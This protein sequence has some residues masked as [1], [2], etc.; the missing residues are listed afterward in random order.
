MHISLIGTVHAENGMANVRTLG[1][2]LDHLQPE[3]IYA[4]IPPGTLPNYLDSSHGN[5]ESAAVAHY[6]VS[7]LVDVVPVDLE[8]P[9]DDFFHESSEMLAFPQIS[10]QIMMSKLKWSNANATNEIRL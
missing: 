6:R 3:V 4:E 10:R 8:K 7:H 5:L 2:I 9:S 1:S